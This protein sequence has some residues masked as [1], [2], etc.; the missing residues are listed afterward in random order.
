[1]N[2]GFYAIRLGELRKDL[3]S[4]NSDNAQGELYL[5]DLADRAAARGGAAV[6]DVPFDETSGINNRVDLAHVTKAAMAR[7]IE[8]HMVNG[9]TFLN[10]DQTYVDADIVGI[11]QDS[12]IGAGVHLS[13]EL[14]KELN[15]GIGDIVYMSDRRRWLGG[16]RSAHGIVVRID[17]SLPNRK[18]RVN[19]ETYDRIVSAKRS[20]QAIHICTM[21]NA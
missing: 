18:V 11:G 19:A 7:L 13:S 16:L 14:A 12:I 1:V 21:L 10:P 4:L 17:E 8:E 6:L 20:G 3:G 5:T 2:A 9:V 15:A